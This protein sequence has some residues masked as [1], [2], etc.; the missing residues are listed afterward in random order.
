MLRDAR[1]I[2]DRTL[3]QVDLCILGGG[4]AGIALAREFID[5]RQS[6][7]LLESGG[8]DFERGT[9]SL[10]AGGATG[11]V[12]EE[13]SPYLTKSRLRYFGGSTN[14]WEG[15]CRPL[16]AI[17]FRER[18]WVPFSGWPIPFSDIVPYYR[19]A[20]EL[21][22]L[23]SFSIPTADSAQPSELPRF[24]RGAS[25]LRHLL[26]SL[27]PPTR[28]GEVY[29]KQLVEAANVTVVLFANAVELST[30]AGA[31]RIETVEAR[32]LT[33]KGFTVGA[34]KFVLACGGIENPRLLLASNTA[35]TRGL[36]NGHDLVGRFFMEHPHLVA[37]AFCYLPPSTSPSRSLEELMGSSPRSRTAIGVSERLQE[38]HRL[39]NCAVEPFKMAR[40]TKVGSFMKGVAS[41]VADIDLGPGKAMEPVYGRLLVRAEQAPN[42]ESRVRLS[43]ETDP[44]GKRRARLEW[45][46]SELDRTSVEKTLECMG[47]CMG[48]A[49][50]ARVWV[51]PTLDGSWPRTYGGSHHM[52]TTRMHSDPLKGVVDTHCR[53]HSVSNLYVAGSSVFTT[54]GFANPTL[55]L[56]ALSLRLADHLKASLSNE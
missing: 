22:Q 42:P 51:D 19:R 37:G 49:G 43:D 55:T 21:C 24:L 5:K 17:D 9:Q 48:Q 11:T 13:H 40:R 16:D 20:A 35:D 25:G 36:G 4:A 33:G 56:V 50:G 34:R 31:D 2:P 32:S 30:N 38:E 7:L 45:R 26:F 52:G 28:F 18:H 54:S 39:L 41:L 15:M 27:S 14:H 1:T 6:V 8:L 23:E 10:Y 47:R 12:L 44:F 3:L 53:V 29:R 46:L